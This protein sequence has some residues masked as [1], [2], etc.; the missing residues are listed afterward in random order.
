[1]TD[2]LKHLEFQGTEEKAEKTKRSKDWMVQKRQ[3]SIGLFSSNNDVL[4]KVIKD[5]Y[6]AARRMLWFETPYLKILR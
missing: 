2:L 3:Y 1:M 4:M 6:V 5:N